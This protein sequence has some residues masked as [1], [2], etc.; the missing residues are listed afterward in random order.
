M[1]MC[2]GYNH[3][4]LNYLKALQLTQYS[5]LSNVL[6]DPH[7]LMSFEVPN[8]NVFFKF[9]NKHLKSVAADV[10]RLRRMDR[11]V[12]LIVILPLQLLVLAVLYTMDTDIGLMDAA[13]SE[14]KEFVFLK[15]AGIH[16]LR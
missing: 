8:E 14:G 3:F 9:M 11:S 6:T 5:L 15:L 4:I 1:A 10:A 12:V 7:E 2:S 16:G 13:E